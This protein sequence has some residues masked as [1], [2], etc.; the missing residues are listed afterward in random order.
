[1]AVPLEGSR[2]PPL[3]PCHFSLGESLLVHSCW[4]TASIQAPEF[5]VICLNAGIILASGRITVVGEATCLLQTN[6]FE[7]FLSHTEES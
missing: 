4:L 7:I 5:Q 3:Q 6:F 2:H 1:M